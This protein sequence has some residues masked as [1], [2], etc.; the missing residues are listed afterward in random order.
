M[1]T[2]K[3]AYSAAAGSWTS[4]T[5]TL[6]SL[7]S[8]SS[9]QS[10]A[11]DNSTNLYVDAL[12]SV[13]IKP[14]TVTAPSTVSVYAYEVGDSGNYTDGCSGTDGAYTLLSPTNL[15]FLGQVSLP[16]S[17]TAETSPAYSLAAA[18]G[19][20]PE[21]WGIVVLNNTGAALDATAGG[22]ASYVGITYT[23]A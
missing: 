22:T 9:R 12:V 23:T 6:N 1:S 5:I 18:F 17:S 21:K 4:I 7:A 14:G 2:T 11:V 15:R 3:I 16:T 8:T 13:T 20:M 10:T 19:H